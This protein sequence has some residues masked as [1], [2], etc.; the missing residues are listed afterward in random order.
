MSSEDENYVT[1]TVKA[2]G[3]EVA[4]PCRNAIVV[5][6]R[7]DGSPGPALHVGDLDQEALPVLADGA[8]SELLSFGVRTGVPEDRIRSVSSTRRHA[9]DTRRRKSGARSYTTSTSMR[10]R[11]P[12]RRRRMSRDDQVTKITVEYKGC[13]RELEAK[14]AMVVVTLDDSSEDGVL[15]G[16]FGVRDLANLA[17]GAVAMVLKLAAKLGVDPNTAKGFILLPALEGDIA[18]A[19]EEAYCVDFG[20][21]DE[22]ARIAEDLGVDADI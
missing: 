22:I 20:A 2:R 4:I 8:V 18:A 1:V 17:H 11:S 5:T 14:S 6:A 12:A 9:A 13:R 16:S 10:T 7:A 19:T 21:R 15:S 3:R